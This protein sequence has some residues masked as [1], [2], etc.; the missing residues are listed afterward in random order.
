MGARDI[1]A[2]GAYVS[3]STRDDT[4]KGL[5]GIKGKLKSFSSQVAKIGGVAI[6]AAAAGAA[7]ATLKAVKTGADIQDLAN[8]YQI[9]TDAVQ[10][11]GFA[12]EQSGTELGTLTNGIRNLQK[13]IGNGTLKDELDALGLSMA[14]LQGMTPEQQLATIAT[15][16]GNVADQEKKMALAM[17]LFGKSGADL[18]PMLNGGADGAEALIETFRQ[19]NITMSA[20]AVAQAA[21]LDDEMGKLGARFNAVVLAVGSKLMPVLEWVVK[22]LNK[23]P[24]LGSGNA[25]TGGQ[26]VGAPAV[27]AATPTTM[28]QG[29]T[30]LDNWLGNAINRGFEYARGQDVNQY[31]I[32]NKLPDVLDI[33]KGIGKEMDRIGRHADR[34]VNKL[35][36]RE[37]RAIE[38]DLKDVNKQIGD[39]MS[40]SISF[41]SFDKRDLT[42]GVFQDIESRQLKELQ[43]MKKLMEKQLEKLG[44][45]KPGLP[46]G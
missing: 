44:K 9:G 19:M 25:I 41:G 18:L 30:P 14:Q 24:N 12:A 1:K 21:Q 38:A 42:G 6:S 17:A 36:I 39:Q 29:G 5:A 3:V 10:A 8:R 32:E 20:E 37:A 35:R 26:V 2:G 7:A 15:A 22:I 33:F 27:A 45:L 16:F 40:K 23:L 31:V 4:D 11:L 34:Q 43:D 46:V 28:T 13:G